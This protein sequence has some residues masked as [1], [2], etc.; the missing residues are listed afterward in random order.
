M[1]TIIEVTKDPSTT[2]Y[3]TNTKGVLFNHLYNCGTYN[4]GN[5]NK[6]D[7]YK[8]NLFESDS[9]DNSVLH[10]VLKNQ[11]YLTSQKKKQKKKVIWIQL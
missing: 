7:D 3:I 4:N 10:Q 2:F 9:T 11:Q 8:T 6:S 1:T 5:Y